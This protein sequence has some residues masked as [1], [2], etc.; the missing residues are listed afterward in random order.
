VAIG[1][2]PGDGTVGMLPIPAGP[3]RNDVRWLLAAGARGD[4]DLRDDDME[5]PREC[6][7]I[8]EG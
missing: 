1:A 7:I 8:L 3:R 6:E 4:G 2:E 5:V